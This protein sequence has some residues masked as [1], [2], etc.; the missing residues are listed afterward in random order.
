M[1]LWRVGRWASPIVVLKPF[2]GPS[3]LC[4][5]PPG[6]FG[7]LPPGAVGHQ[8]DPRLPTGGGLRRLV[9]VL[10]QMI[11]GGRAGTTPTDEVGR[12]ARPSGAVE[13]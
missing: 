4:G 2:A 10:D 6:T 8:T 5:R 7:P 12:A 9:Q 13:R 11:Q 3:D 1:R